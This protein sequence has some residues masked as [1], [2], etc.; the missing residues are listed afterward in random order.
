MLSGGLSVKAGSLRCF[1]LR[2]EDEKDKLRVGIAVTRN[3]K[4]AV[5]RNRIKRLMRDVLRANLSSFEN[6][7]RGKSIDMVFLCNKLSTKR[8][9]QCK[10]LTEETKQLL[11]AVIQHLKGHT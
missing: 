3:V 6:I 7:V 10:E 2:K 9:S 8:T 4:N 11:D 1:Y 5:G